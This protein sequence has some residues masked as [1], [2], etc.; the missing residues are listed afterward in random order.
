MEAVWISF[1]FVL[2]FLVRPLGMPPLTGYLAA[3]FALSAFGLVGGE[4][5]SR[6]AHAGVLLL[7][8]S[9]GLKLRWKSLVRP[10]VWGGAILHLVLIG[11]LIGPVLHL[12]LGLELN[13]AIL[14]TLAVSFSSTVVAAKVLEEKK[15]LRAFHGRVA[16][17]I[18][19]V[20]DIVAV[21]ILASAGG[22]SPSPWALTVLA[23]PVLRKVFLVILERCGHG[24]LLVLYG[25]VLALVVG[26]VGFDYVGLSPEL[27]ALVMGA[28]IATHR[29]ST[30]LSNALWGL[31]EIFLIGFFLQIGM[32]GLPSLD[33]LRWAAVLA[34]LLPVKAVLFFFVLILFRLRARTAFLAGLSLATYS[35][36]G[37]IVANLAVQNGW[38][39]ADWLVMLAVAVALSFAVAAPLNRYAHNLYRVFEQRLLRFESPRRHPDDKPLH[40]GY[41][42]VLIIGMGRVGT[43][44]YRFF[45]QR[46][47]RVVGLDSDPG[48]VEEHKRK[49]RRVLYADA[50]DPGLW[51]NIDLSGV[52]AILLAIPDREANT[53]AAKQLR[54]AGYKGL[55]CATVRFPEEVKAI[56]DAGAD[57]AYYFYDEVG[58]GFAENIWERLNPT[59]NTAANEPSLRPSLPASQVSGKNE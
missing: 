40:V 6:L 28:T 14:I 2:G 59:K 42:N 7:L 38:M 20:Q 57:V 47:Q 16:I 25:L 39:A 46:K 37:L 26:G 35:E 29:R 5:L 27:G 52:R 48:K 10:E 32:S 9:V 58:V 12:T 17:G 13:A 23:L 51:Q 44:A 15:E 43:G 30:E 3:G 55:I 8:F 31:K 22:H 24:E 49:G 21:A 54:L 53:A 36:F 50:E 56:I 34:L 33:T 45:S 1:A 41:S 18:L 11:L 19:V 4:V